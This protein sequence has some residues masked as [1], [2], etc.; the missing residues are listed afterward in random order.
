MVRPPQFELGS[1]PRM[2]EM[3]TLS[4][5]TATPVFIID[6]PDIQSSTRAKALIEAANSEPRARF[7]II[8][9]KYGAPSIAG[10]FSDRFNAEQFTIADFSLGAL[11]E[12]ISD[13]FN[14]NVSEAAAVATR[15]NFT[16]ER[17]KMHAHPTYFAGISPE[18]LA[19][20]IAANRRNDLIQ[21][22]VDGA[23]MAIVVSDVSDVRLS[24]R[25]RCEFL[26]EIISRQYVCGEN[27]DDVMAVELARK[28]AQ[29]KD[30][31][32][33]P[34][35]FV[36]SFVQ[37]GILEFAEGGV[38]FPRVYVRDYL[39]AQYLSENP[40]VAA[41][42]F[43]FDRIDEDL[44]VI[45]IYSELGP[46]VRV[47]EDI[48]SQIEADV[49]ELMKRPHSMDVLLNNKIEF[50]SASNFTR[51]TQ[52]RDLVLKAI[53]YVGENGTDLT[54]KQEASGYS[55]VGI[56]LGRAEGKQPWRFGQGRPA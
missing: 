28:M 24:R 44:N 2:Q 38:R 18:M 39:M 19:A 48:I 23:L 30:I 36:Q 16:F 34:V 46:S 42:Y 15:L 35:E 6:D 29:E 13:N 14:Y 31:E 47:V 50:S 37:S 27:L 17:F 41:T 9:K 1:L 32:L 22:A 40:N 10:P 4:K 12:F 25:W 8:A 11:S 49:E 21:L 51:F 45:N 53:E 56:A 33:R 3:A 55:P 54:R 20:L 5:N 26:K 43:D 7:V 52:R